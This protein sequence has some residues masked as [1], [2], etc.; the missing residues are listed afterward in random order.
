M[1]LEE[2]VLCE[3]I[4]YRGLLTQRIREE[5]SEELYLK[6][7]KLSKILKNSI[8][9][10][11]S[12]LI[13]SQ[14]DIQK[15]YEKYIE[16]KV[17][18]VFGELSM[19]DE[20]FDYHAD[21]IKKDFSIEKF[22]KEQLIQIQFKIVRKMLFNINSCIYSF[23]S[24]R[25]LTNKLTDKT[26][27]YKLFILFIFYEI[28][29]KDIYREFLYT[30]LE[31]HFEPNQDNNF[32]ELLAEKFFL[33]ENMKESQIYKFMCFH[34]QTFNYE[35]SIIK[36]IKSLNKE[37]QEYI[38]SK[39]ITREATQALIIT[40]GKTD[41]KH[42]KKALLRLKKQK[43]AVFLDLN[44]QFEEYEYTV[45]DSE[46]ATMLRTYSKV[47]QEKRYIMIFDR[48]QINGKKDVKKLFN[49]DEA[50]KEQGN[51]VY[52]MFIPKIDEKLD[53]ICI[54]FFYKQEEV[55]SAWYN[56]K[57]LFYG[58]EFDTETSKSLCGKYKT[59]KLYPKA[60][61]ILDGDKHKKVYYIDDENKENNI[62]LSKN[63]FTNN[64]INDVEGFDD[65]DIENFKLIF[66]VIEKIIND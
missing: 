25:T 2:V 45:G 29:N 32:I 18:E 54:E 23:F 5:L 20:D 59:D 36:E 58:N 8:V 66:D 38:F 10:G 49:K 48:D 13:D 55:K 30:I 57:R 27:K 15:E 65:F 56:G 7:I 14:I 21:F 1:K 61:D 28:I 52:Y 35:D 6:N 39:E 24:K 11:K 40:E 3:S 42:L 47:E 46:L 22:V 60:L 62:A 43:E 17:K 26:N 12:K 64:I 33:E 44:I 9:Q 31:S 63:A 19:T 53:E 16:N 4:E 37:N 50:F 51:N 34:N 41:W